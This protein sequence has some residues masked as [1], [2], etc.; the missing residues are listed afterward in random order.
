ME[1][2]D[3]TDIRIKILDA[4]SSEFICAVPVPISVEA[5]FSKYRLVPSAI[6]FGSLV[7]GSSK[8]KFF[9]IQNKGQFDFDFELYNLK[10]DELKELIYEEIQLYHSDK[11]ID[12][13]I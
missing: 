2:R 1:L 13:Y 7:Y 4:Q 8:E 5:V 10:I 9:D 6:N 11:A 12:K 3:N